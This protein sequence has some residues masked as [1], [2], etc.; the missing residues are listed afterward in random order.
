MEKCW[1]KWHVTFLLHEQS[2]DGSEEESWEEALGYCRARETDL[3]SLLTE[4]ELR[5]AQALIQPDGATEQFW[6]GLR[7]VNCWVWV[8]G[9]PLAYNQEHQDH[10]CP[11]RKRCG[12]LSKTEDRKIW[13]CEDSLN[14]TCIWIRSLW[15][16]NPA[17]AKMMS[18]VY[19]M[20]DV[21]YLTCL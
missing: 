18:N 13:D 8:N 11:V 4:A 9:K 2:H 7:Y 6:I 20:L 15:L 12:A 19:V 21:S 17:I 1:W 14:F 16:C 5:Q 3:P 10:V